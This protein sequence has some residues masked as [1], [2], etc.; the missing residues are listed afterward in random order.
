MNVKK[1]K[2]LKEK[3]IKK[4][5]SLFLTNEYKKLYKGTQRGK[6]EKKKDKDKGQMI[7]DN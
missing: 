1:N 5:S 3:Y 6:M 7:K 4:N 2:Y